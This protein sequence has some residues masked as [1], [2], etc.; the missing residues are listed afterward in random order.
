MS[1]QGFTLSVPFRPFDA[2]TLTADRAFEAGG[3]EPPVFT[4]DTVY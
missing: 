3:F 4:M 2:Y 1:L